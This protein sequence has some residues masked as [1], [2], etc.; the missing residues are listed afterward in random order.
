[1]R[2]SL[3]LSPLHRF[4][5]GFDNVSRLLDAA[6]RLDDQAVAYP[7][8]NIEKTGET[9]YRITMAVAGFAEDDLSVVLT[10]NTLVIAG[11]LDRADDA[12]SRF[13]HRGIAGRA[14]ERKFELA[15]HLRVE[16]ASFVNGLLHV[17]LVREVP[18]EKQPRRIA[19]QS[20][21]APKGIESQA[22]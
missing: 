13:L 2:T 21:S 8:Y 20:A 10:E 5:I 11:R 18:E 1:M 7:P 22:A 16:G 17:D 12:P 9:Q 4:A 15:D 6:S 19:I 14:F 3:D